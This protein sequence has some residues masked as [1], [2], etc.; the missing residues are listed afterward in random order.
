MAVFLSTFNTHDSGG[1]ETESFTV[2]RI[3]L[4]KI[5]LMR[6]LE[7]I[8]VQLRQFSDFFLN[9][10]QHL[11]RIIPTNTE[12]QNKNL[13]MAWENERESDCT[14]P[15]LSRNIWNNLASKRFLGLTPLALIYT[16]LASEPIIFAPKPSKADNNRRKKLLKLYYRVKQ[17]Y[18]LR[19]ISTVLEQISL[20]STSKAVTV[21]CMKRFLQIFGECIKNTPNSQNLPRKLNQ[22]LKQQLSGYID[23]VKQTRDVTCH[24]Y[25]LAKKLLS[26]DDQFVY[27]NSAGNYLRMV[28]VTIAI[29][30]ISTYL[31]YFRNLF[32]TL[33]Q[34]R[35]LGHMQSLIRFI[36]NQDEIDSDQERCMDIINQYHSDLSA[37]LKEISTETPEE[38]ETL[39][40]LWTNHNKR[41]QAIEL[42]QGIIQRFLY[43]Y[44]DIQIAAF[45]TNSVET[46][47]RFL[48]VS[49]RASNYHCVLELIE[50]IWIVLPN[51]LGM[52]SESRKLIEQSASSLTTLQIN[53]DINQETLQMFH[54][55]EE[56]RR[57][58]EEFLE[59]KKT[60]DHE[61]HNLEEKLLQRLNRGGKGYFNNIFMIDSKIQAVKNVFREHS[62]EELHRK[63]ETLRA[64]DLNELQ[65]IFDTKQQSILDV[66]E[67]YDCSSIALLIQNA[68]K[69]PK[70]ATL[71]IEYWL[72]E[73]CEILISTKQFQ[74]NFFALQYDLQL[75]YGR[76]FRNYLAHD[77]L[78]YNL[79]TC[80]T[81]AKVLVNAL[82]MTQKS[83][84]LFA[85]TKPSLESEITNTFTD[86]S[87]W[88]NEQRALA[89][90]VVDFR[91]ND[92]KRA[93]S[94]GALIAGKFWTVKG[95]FEGLSLMG[96]SEMIQITKTSNLRTLGSN[97]RQT[98]MLV[99]PSVSGKWNAFADSEWHMEM[100]LHNGD[101]TRAF[102]NLGDHSWG[103]W[104]KSGW[105]PQ[106]IYPC[107]GALLSY[108]SSQNHH[109]EILDI[110]M[111]FGPDFLKAWISASSRD[112]LEY[113]IKKAPPALTEV[114]FH[115]I[116]IHS[117]VDYLKHLLSKNS[118]DSSH[119]TVAVLTNHVS[120]FDYLMS[121]QDSIDDFNKTAELCARYGRIEMLRI[122]FH[123]VRIAQSVLDSA[124]NSSTQHRKWEA[125]LLLLKEGAN[126][127]IR[128]KTNELSAGEIAIKMGNLKLLKSFSKVIPPSYNIHC[129]LSM[130]ARYGS[131]KMV[132]NLVEIGCNLWKDR[133]II[134]NSFKNQS[135][136]SIVQF[137]E[138]SILDFSLVSTYTDT[139]APN[140][141]GFH[142]WLQVLHE[143][144]IVKLF[145][146]SSFA[147]DVTLIELLQV[148]CGTVKRILK[149]IANFGRIDDGYCIQSV[150][151]Y[152]EGV[153][154]RDVLFS[155]ESKILGIPPTVIHNH[156]EI[157]FI[158]AGGL[159]KHSFNVKIDVFNIE[160]E[161]PNIL[162]TKKSYNSNQSPSEFC[163]DLIETLD[164]HTK[165]SALLANFELQ[166]QKFY[167][168]RVGPHF[169]LTKLRSSKSS[170]FLQR[171]LN[172]SN[173]K[174]ETI[175]HHLHSEVNE[176][177]LDLFISNGVEIAAVDKKGQIALVH[178]L[179]RQV[180]WDIFKYLLDH[181]IQSDV[182]DANGV[183]IFN[184]Q[185]QEG[186]TLLY[187]AVS[188]GR[189]RIVE[190]LLDHE[191][192]PTV[193]DYCG[194]F[195]LYN[196]VL[197]RHSAIVYALVKQRPDTINL[198]YCVTG[199]T[200]FSVAATLN[201]VELVRLFLNNG[202]DLG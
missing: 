49:L 99:D 50:N 130:A 167:T 69:I 19:K 94:E 191:V 66:L 172:A 119:S 163:C 124:L 143:Q 42:L 165:S 187:H 86:E 151:F 103:Q 80:S 5:S 93:V 146:E 135:D 37:E 33:R 27:Y 147:N 52:L 186:K 81:N 72:L 14:L 107:L 76:N 181:C 95:I 155:L 64:R 199:D 29:L 202:A 57:I 193:R 140:G 196:A 48:D 117:S 121:N 61:K 106:S 96:L 101:F 21:A 168:L 131:V 15:N 30:M 159:I 201:N 157:L 78:S 197:L 127:W 198:Q 23:F 6:I 67:K 200:P 1:N 53:F 84:K 59:G 120:F 43:K 32:G 154:S 179:A 150:Q 46:V 176:E 89:Q 173:A 115:A 54:C 134:L 170:C 71:A 109:E 90:S 104:V 18:S 73:L 13:Q 35:N 182:R 149:K 3:V 17:L 7:S 88:L 156:K 194:R 148:D 40:R 152:D 137:V 142:R 98:L 192:D 62:V 133:S 75:I 162:R 174:G 158:Y 8:A 12:R 184:M 105:F 63:L 9:I 189:L 190:F 175:L 41:L 128:L 26:L 87:G 4:N 160:T 183:H 11:V 118:I 16:V 55:R 144:K 132:K 126:P 123:S 74:D 22:V 51:D 70:E 10:T 138:S 141:I 180:S 45:S 77:G 129:L 116:T 65:L 139:V 122:L 91:F 161:F 195:P 153:E 113:L 24:D 166:Y 164:A 125:A 185:D 145:I 82:V 111:Y 110:L 177:L 169:A 31:E 92:A 25:P 56:V 178:I 188:Y 20:N 100:A 85:G 114:Q 36:G 112:F 39:E 68:S 108:L 28:R 102:D 58:V 79:L 83:W 136:P 44:R 34:C 60:P 97:I 47:H 38:S 171:L 2:Y